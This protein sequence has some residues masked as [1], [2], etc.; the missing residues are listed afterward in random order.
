MMSQ[1]RRYHLRGQDVDVTGDV[2]V[3]IHVFPGS[4]YVCVC[5]CVYACA[6][7]NLQNSRPYKISRQWHVGMYGFKP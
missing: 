3:C 7:V 5:V 4:A 1:W 2:C 6:F